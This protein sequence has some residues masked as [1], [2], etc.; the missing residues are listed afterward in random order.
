MA[1][2]PFLIAFSIL[3]FLLSAQQ[4]LT[5]SLRGAFQLERDPVKKLEIYYDLATEIKEH[6][7]EAAFLYADTLENMAQKQGNKKAL[8]RALD[9]RGDA[10]VEKGQVEEAIALFRKELVLFEELADQQGQA[11]CLNSLGIAFKELAQTDSTIIYLLKAAK[12]QED[13]GGMSELA[14]V[15]SNIG[16]LY[17]DKQVYDKGI[18]FLQK[19]LKIRQ[20]NG[21]EKRSI[22]TLNNLAVAYG[23][24]GDLALAMDYARQ[25]ID[26]ALKYDNKYV[27]GVIS[28][29]ICHLLHGKGEN[30]EA[31]RWCEQ[32]IRYLEAANRRPN[33]VFPLVNLATIYNDQKK[34][35]AALEVA[36]EGYQLMLEYKQ[37]EPLE[38]YYE[39]MAKAYE[40]LGNYEQ[41][42]FWYKKFMVL[43]DSLYKAE[44]V[45]DMAEIETKYETSKKEAEI[46]S[47]NLQLTRQQG[48]LF[49]Q[50]TWIF[51]L[52]LGLLA[53][54][55]V[56][57]LY[58]NRYRLRQK[59]ILDAAV[60]R[61]QQLGLNAVIE[62]Q[63]AERKRI[64]KD[65][66]DGIAQELVAV[67]LQFNALEN[68]LRRTVPE[69]SGQLTELSR[70]LDESC[71]ELRNISHVMLPP[72]LEQ[73]GLAPSL[74][75][76]LRNTL[77]TTGL[78]VEFD[79]GEIP[80]SLDHRIAIGVYRIAQE[81]INNIVKHA[82]AAKVMFQLYAAG[83]NLI[84]RIEDDGKGFDFEAARKKGSMGLLNI[85]SRV[86]TLGGVYFTEP[87]QPQGTVSTVRVPFHD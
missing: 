55:L 59:A 38:V 30:D 53:F 54:I 62:A 75:M 23:S 3:S 13:L 19:A 40:G 48:R 61:E 46:A 73:H 31:I 18:E 34:Y 37:V 70:Q 24:K 39:E 7:L 84:L 43:D 15:Y 87:G 80:V 36:R 26:L 33:L 28:G 12:I 9:L 64:A 44:T 56:G 77:Q 66:H 85:L 41:A 4:S 5:D 20:E 29:G 76:L 79:C 17:V 69:E 22:Y 45:R 21:E 8:A 42:Y 6:N 10:L 65:L 1:R 71:T 47:Q 50:R 72:A 74:E 67:K 32:S 81:L 68:K 14:S 35:N 86:N 49:R 16:N 82:E 11:M 78:K 58:Y 51:G 27:A 83:N 60:I 2:G 57:S 25:G 52:G 63:E